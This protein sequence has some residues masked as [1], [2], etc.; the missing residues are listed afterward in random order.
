MHEFLIHK[1]LTGELFIIPF[2]PLLTEHEDAFSIS[3]DDV[4]ELRVAGVDADELGH[5]LEERLGGIERGDP[6]Q[7]ADPPP[8]QL[9]ARVSGNVRAQG[10]ADEVEVAHVRAMLVL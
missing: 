1:R 9:F 10:V 7:L 8:D 5:R 6:R 4:D 3:V 2:F